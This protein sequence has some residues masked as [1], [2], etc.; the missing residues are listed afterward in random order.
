VKTKGVKIKEIPY[1]CKNR[2]EGDSKFNFLVINNY[3][4]L[5]RILLGYNRK[6][7]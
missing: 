3:F 5:L 1:I 2:K 7:S 6:L 4:K